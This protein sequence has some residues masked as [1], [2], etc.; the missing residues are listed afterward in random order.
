MSLPEVRSELLDKQGQSTTQPAHCILSSLRCGPN[1]EVNGE[2]LPMYYIPPRLLPITLSLP[3]PPH[4]FQFLS[5]LLSLHTPLYIMICT[6]VSAIGPLCLLYPLYHSPFLSVP[7]SLSCLFV[8]PPVPPSISL[9]PMAI[10][11]PHP[12]PSTCFPERGDPSPRCRA[13][14]ASARRLPHCAGIAGFRSG[15]A[16]GVIRLYVDFQG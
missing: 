13:F 15:C 14:P 3:I 2:A 10:L 5:T 11:I 9:P 16:H 12:D 4:L 1:F 8:L 7:L 6:S